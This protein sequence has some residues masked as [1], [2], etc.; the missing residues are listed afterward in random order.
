M[1]S[2]D[3]KL[4]EQSLQRATGQHTGTALDSALEELGWYDA[5]DSDRRDAVSALFALQGAAGVSSSAL[6]DLLARS[7]GV[8]R[9]AT[10]VLPQ[11]GRRSPAGELTGDRLRVR[12][13]AIGAPHEQVAIPTDT[14][15]AVVARS[16]V[17]VRPVAGMDP[18]LGLVAV[19]GELPAARAVLS[20]TTRWPA[21]L[22][23]GQLALAY[24]LVGASRTMLQL[25]RDHAVERVQ[26][27]RPIA[28]FQAVRHRLADALVAIE[29]AHACADAAWDDE[30]ALSASIAKAVA[31]AA[32]RTVGKHAQQVLGG[33][34]YT[35][36]H[37]LHQYVR[38]TLVLDQLLGAGSVLT[39]EIGAQLL[40]ARDLPELLPL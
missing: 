11:L 6:S 35:T 18:R 20:P 27:G 1:D 33:M 25:A 10:V 12:G 4:F 19:T 8:T 40:R 31:G 28:G 2:G 7:L 21:A 14:Q 30:A 29:G 36:D 37:P 26:F 3:R 39:R 13:L 22:A 15:I 9:E 32:A 24:E 16:D 5:L 38:R 17:D 34:G 23:A